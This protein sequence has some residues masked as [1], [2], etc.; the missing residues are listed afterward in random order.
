MSLL[1]MRLW[2][3]SRRRFRGPVQVGGVESYIATPTVEYPK[4]KAIL[5]L[6]DL[7]G[8]KFKNHLVIADGYAPTASR[9]SSTTS[10]GDALPEDTSAPGKV[11]LPVYL[12]KHSA[13]RAV[14]I[15]MKVMRAL[16]AEGVTRVGA[17]GFCYGAR[18][19][20]DLAF[21][22]EVQ[23]V[24]VTHPSLIQIPADLEKF[25]LQSRAPLLINSCEVDHVFPKE[26]QEKADEILGGGKFAP[27]NERTYWEGCEHGFAV[28]ADVSDPKVKAGKEVAFKAT[29]KFLIKHL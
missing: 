3:P 2:C 25:A 27:G 16:R 9:S 5:F 22:N 8:I 12:S 19:A 17:I 18:P 10:S 24:A 11:D 21:I 1:A 26:A 20:F 6:S 15:S 23:V 29:I 4:D 13:A 14:E 28:R 7:F